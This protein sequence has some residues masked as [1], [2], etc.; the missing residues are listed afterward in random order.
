MG[1][2]EKRGGTESVKDRQ[3]NRNRRRERERERERTPGRLGIALNQGL[4]GIRLPADPT[5]RLHEDE[6]R[7]DISHT[8][9]MRL[10]EKGYTGNTAQH[11]SNTVL[12]NN[13]T[14]N[15]YQQ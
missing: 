1:R 12:I 4:S 10:S 3:R 5:T 9:N 8:F 2:V 6:S 14:K 13:T 7:K 15:D 11:D